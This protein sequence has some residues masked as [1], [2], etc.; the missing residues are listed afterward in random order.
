MCKI[1]FMPNMELET[2]LTVVKIGLTSQYGA[3]CAQTDMLTD[4]TGANV[5]YLSDLQPQSGNSAT[6]DLKEDDIKL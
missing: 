3:F 4:M 6:V 1:E 2:G 5:F